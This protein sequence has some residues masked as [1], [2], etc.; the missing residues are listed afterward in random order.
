M[1]SQEKEMADDKKQ[2]KQHRTQRTVS[3]RKTEGERKEN[4]QTDN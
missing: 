1:G 4:K 3:A 2:H